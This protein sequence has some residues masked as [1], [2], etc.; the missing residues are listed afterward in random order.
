[1]KRALIIAVAL[2]AVVAGLLIRQRAFA[3]RENRAKIAALQH[4]YGDMWASNATTIEAIS[5]ATRAELEAAGINVTSLV[6][7][8]AAGTADTDWFITYRRNGCAFIVARGGGAVVLK[9]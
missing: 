8:T 9:E 2:F 1:M 6:I 4:V 5:A 7:N 3:H